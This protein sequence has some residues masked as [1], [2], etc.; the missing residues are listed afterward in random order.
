MDGHAICDR[1]MGLYTQ[2]A[3]VMKLYSQ[4]TEAYFLISLFQRKLFVSETYQTH[5]L[6]CILSQGFMF[7]SPLHNEFDCV[8]IQ[9]YTRLIGT[10]IMVLECR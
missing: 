2:E 10:L 6:G 8:A 7:I 1:E 5:M 9:V 3:Q 4:F